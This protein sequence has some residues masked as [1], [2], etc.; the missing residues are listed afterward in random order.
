[1]SK[2]T[3]NISCALIENY[4]IISYKGN[5]DSLDKTKIYFE[6]DVLRIDKQNLSSYLIYTDNFQNDINM[7]L[8]IH[9]DDFITSI[10]HI[11]N[12]SKIC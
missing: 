1:M 11:K 8:R 5:L 2:I 6:D 9:E 4:Y 12:K 10:I 3:S 7:N